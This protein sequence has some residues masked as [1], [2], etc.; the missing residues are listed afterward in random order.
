MDLLRIVVICIIAFLILRD[1]G[2]FFGW[3]GRRLIV[4]ILLGILLLLVYLFTGQSF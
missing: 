4:S 1:P 3:L 2:K